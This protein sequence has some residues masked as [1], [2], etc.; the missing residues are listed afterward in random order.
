MPV[1][2]TVLIFVCI[3]AG[4]LL[5]F[6]ACVYGPTALRRHRYRSGEPWPFEPVWFCP[7]PAALPQ[8]SQDLL[9]LDVRER[10]AIETRPR[11]AITAGGDAQT[12]GSSAVLTPTAT[13]RGGAHGDW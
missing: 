11:A 6:A 5:L 2:Q 1:Y 12:R 9:A 10:T 13:A 7:H 3:P 8:E 4:L